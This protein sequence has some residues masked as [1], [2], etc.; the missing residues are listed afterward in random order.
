[1]RDSIVTRAQV[2]SFGTGCEKVAENY[3][4]AKVLLWTEDSWK[5]EGANG[6]AFNPTI[7]Y[8]LVKYG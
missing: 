4:N 1:M 6:V 7:S 8:L 3:P 5:I 2:V